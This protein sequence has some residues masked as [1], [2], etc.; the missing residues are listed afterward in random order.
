MRGTVFNVQRFSTR[1]GPGIRTTVFLKGCP[2]QCPWCH[3][4]E[5]RDG[6]PEIAIRRGRC[7]GCGNCVEVCPERESLEDDPVPLE[8][9]ACGRCVAACPTGARALMGAEFSS[10]GLVEQLLKDRIF[11][12]E[13]GGGVT[14]SGGEPLA[15]PEFLL[16]CLQRCRAEGVHT[17]VDTCGCCSREA[18]LGAAS[19]ADLFLFDIKLTDPEAHK[20]LVGAP[21]EPIL[22]N[23]R[24]LAE[25]H[26][27]IWLRAPVI[28]GLTDGE[29]HAAS[30]AALAASLPAVRRV[31]LLPYHRTGQSKFEQLGR[32]YEMKEIQPPTDAQMRELAAVFESSGIEVTIGG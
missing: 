13:S 22:D 16:D 10:A 29:F 32:D 27:Q 4:P 6:D 25:H 1:D 20:R 14:F 26:D 8:C 5:G 28:P 2:L 17:A 18:L 11:F 30:I 12:D 24:A 21:L 23:L 31:S 19:L 9:T 15:Q 3:N 7:I